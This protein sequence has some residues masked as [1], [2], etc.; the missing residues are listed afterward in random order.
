MKKNLKV[1]S[2]VLA[3]TVLIMCVSLAAGVSARK[4]ITVGISMN[5]LNNPFFVTVVEGAR[6]MADELGVKL[7]VTD[8]QNR[9]GKEITNVENL[10]QQKVDVLILDPSDSNAIIPSV[11]NANDA[12]I[13]VLT[14]DRK[15]NDGDVITHIGFDA[16]RSGRIAGQFLVD[17]LNGKGK[18]VEIMGIM[19][20]SVAQDR[21]KGFNQ[22]MDKNPGMKVIAK[23]TANFDR[24]QAMSVMEN[25]LQAQPEIDGIYAA[26]DEMALGVLAAIEA[27][28]RLDEITLIGCDAID[29]SMEAIRKRKMEATI[30]EPPYFLGKNAVKTAVAIYNGKKVEDEVIL[31]N[32]LVTKE[33]IDIIKTRD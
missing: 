11:L 27:A 4:P 13:P 15:A 26:N 30:A 9:P 17:S 10:I 22:I 24:G 29:D 1:V 23:Q 32:Q 6:A 5:T 33:N 20:T 12:N 16:I 3:V 28:G 21:S 7:I 31:E 2:V 25:I 14:I 8:A 18:I 19:G